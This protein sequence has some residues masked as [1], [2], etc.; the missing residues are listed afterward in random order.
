MT[1]GMSSTQANAL[2]NTYRSGGGNITAAAC[3]L[4]I[5]TADPGASGTTS[6]ATSHPATR[7]VKSRW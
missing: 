7:P 6:L 5:H 4:D 2:L 3:Y 1:V